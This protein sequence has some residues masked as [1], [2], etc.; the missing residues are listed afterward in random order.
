MFLEPK[1]M[2][3][4]KILLIW[5]NFNGFLNTLSQLTDI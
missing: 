3:S 2:F 4:I 1:K 5:G